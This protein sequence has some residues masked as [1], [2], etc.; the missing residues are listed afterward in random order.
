M[1]LADKKDFSNRSSQ[2]PT[3]KALQVSAALSGM[4]SWEGILSDVSGSYTGTP[5]DG[6]EPVQDADDL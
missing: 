4:D 5:L 3:E 2:A 6:L 1:I